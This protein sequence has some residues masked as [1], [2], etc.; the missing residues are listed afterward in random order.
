MEGGCV[1]GIILLPIVRI[2]CPISQPYVDSIDVE[3]RFIDMNLVLKTITAAIYTSYETIIVDDEGIEPEDAFLAEPVG[4]KLVLKF[5]S[6]ADM[7]KQDAM[8]D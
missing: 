1:S 8:Y 6:V 7:T 4:R 2:F 3:M 5:R